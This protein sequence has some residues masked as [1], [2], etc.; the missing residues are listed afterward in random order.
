MD[1]LLFRAFRSSCT[2]SGN[3]FGFHS[4][5]LMDKD[6]RIFHWTV[7]WKPWKAE[8]WQ[9][10]GNDSQVAFSVDRKLWSFPVDQ[11][12]PKRSSSFLLIKSLHIGNHPQVA[13][14][15][16]QVHCSCFE[17]ARNCHRS[18][19]CG[20]SPSQSRW[21]P[22]SC[23]PWF[24][25]VLEV[26][27]PSVFGDGIKMV[28]NGNSQ[29]PDIFR[30]YSLRSRWSLYL[31]RRHTTCTC[32]KCPKVQDAKPVKTLVTPSSLPWLLTSSLYSTLSTPMVYSPGLKLPTAS[33]TLCFSKIGSQS[34]ST[35]HSWDHLG[36]VLCKTPIRICFSLRY[37]LEQLAMP[38]DCWHLISEM[39][40]RGW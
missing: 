8:K 9:F 35:W 34:A 6:S 18:A 40:I 36:Q 14:L 11:I 37:M 20:R 24:K 17:I 10:N 31:Y 7:W 4:L 22:Y 12:L 33:A 5:G 21:P 3:R 13:S 29:Y 27:L 23:G 28:S 32:H 26:K 1:P 2:F 39:Q 25:G 15:V 19:I 16:I 30:W 38:S